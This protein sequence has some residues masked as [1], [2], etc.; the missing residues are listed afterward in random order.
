MN[1]LGLLPVVELLENKHTASEIPG[2]SVTETPET[3]KGHLAGLELANKESFE[4]GVAISEGT[5]FRCRDLGNL[6][7]HEREAVG[8]HFIQ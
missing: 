5:R 7:H 1:S 4:E 6:C 8:T 2:S 3:P